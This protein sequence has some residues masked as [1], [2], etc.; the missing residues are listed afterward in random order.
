MHNFNSSISKKFNLLISLI[1]EL[2]LETFPNGN[3]KSSFR[4]INIFAII[5]L[6]IID[7]YIESDI[8]NLRINYTHLEN[9]ILETKILLHRRWRVISNFSINSNFV[10]SPSRFRIIL[11]FS[12]IDRRLT[13]CIAE[14]PRYFYRGE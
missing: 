10:R 5:L 12:R 11:E 3:Q 4:K 8:S 6:I 14:H 9:A 2:I 7:S 13:V 1:Q